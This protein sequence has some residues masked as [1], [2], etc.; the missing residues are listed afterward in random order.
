MRM[1]ESEPWSWSGRS[2]L[3]G[4]SGFPVTPVSPY[5]SNSASVKLIHCEKEAQ[6]P[7]SYLMASAGINGS[8]QTTSSKDSVRPAVMIRIMAYTAPGITWYPICTLLSELNSYNSKKDI[9]FLTSRDFK[10][11]AYK[12]HQCSSIAGSW[13]LPGPDRPGDQTFEISYWVFI[14]LRMEISWTSSLIILWH[15]GVDPLRYLSCPAASVH[16]RCP[17]Y[18]SNLKDLFQYFLKPHSV[19]SLFQIHMLLLTIHVPYRRSTKPRRWR[20]I[21]EKRPP[22]GPNLATDRPVV[23]LA[24]L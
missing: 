23:D 10:R 11:Q 24:K 13:K 22:T 4:G 9:L 16:R 8:R 21:S 6:V 3:I 15:V 5:L 12:R 7:D 14:N 1:W 19:V 2:N 17:K 20:K 18:V